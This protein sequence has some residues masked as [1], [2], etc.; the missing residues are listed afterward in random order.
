MISLVVARDRNGAIGKDGDIPWHAPEDLAFFQR[1]TLGSALIMGRRTW[2]S[3]PVRPLGRR[4][5]IVVSSGHVDG[6]HHV[7]PSVEAAIESAISAGY[8]RISGIGGFGIFEA[9]L[10]MSQRMLITE[11]DL[12]VEG[13][14]TWFPEFDEGDWQVT[15]RIPLRADAPRC[16]LREWMRKT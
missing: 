6:P 3:L 10:P 2:E 7:V 11:V 1:E 9:L 15:T 5:N 8:A 12:A 13:A 14:D 16:E 4:L